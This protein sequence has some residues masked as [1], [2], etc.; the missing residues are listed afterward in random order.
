MKKSIFHPLSLITLF[1][2]AALAGNEASSQNPSAPQTAC[3]NLQK[4][5]FSSI[6]D[7]PT[8][9]T[10]TH[11]IEADGDAPAYCQVRG[12]V[13]PSIG[14]ELQLPAFDWNQKFLAV[15]CGGFCG[16][17]D[18][19]SC[20]NGLRRGYAC[21]ASD[22]GHKSHPG[23]ALWAY[24][25]LQAKIDHAYRATHVSA[26]A[27]KAIT[28]NYY[29]TPPRH[30]Y[31][32]GCSTGG[33][34]AMV[35]AQRFPWDF[36]GIIAGAP[37]LSVTGVH[38]AMLWTIRA[39]TD[40]RGKPLFSREDL[41]RAHAAVLQKCDLD[42]GVKDGIVSDPM[43]CAFDP[44]QLEC[45]RAGD[46]HCLSKVQVD[47]LKKVYRGPTTSKGEKI[48]PGALPGSELGLINSS[49]P[50]Q[51]ISGMNN[52]VANEF[53]YAAFPTDPGPD[54]NPA[55]FNFDRDP[56]RLGVMETLSSGTNPNLEKFKASGGKL[57][58]Y[59]GLNDH[60]QAKSTIEY[61]ETVIKT[62]G[63]L[64]AT[65][66]FFRLFTVPA[67]DHCTGGNGAFAVDYLEYLEAWV[68]RGEAPA[69]MIGSHVAGLDLGEAF[70]LKFP[71]E[72]SSQIDFTRP[73]YP[74]PATAKYNGRGNP[75]D[76]GNFHPRVDTRA[77]EKLTEET[78]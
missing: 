27:G 20:A 51:V 49:L 45:G 46:R 68:E 42:D 56:K 18:P 59:V 67:M 8:Q 44:A 64:S 41:Q 48:Y 3:Q 34:Q 4:N 23:D 71:L 5:S 6:P 38:M 7:A 11:F 61:Y 47:A 60:Y 21:L 30:A 1:F 40:S 33:R 53:R 13:Y 43:H 19:K 25:N 63:G 9:I 72:K 35:E 17:I 69:L 28:E 77:P 50:P 31:F 58:A 76:A 29:Q 2:I 36:D 73:L 10:E 70:Y 65:Q 16:A 78:R 24:N 32:M 39:L 62:M 75:D 57:I 74:Y 54:W 26:L 66:D 37:S 52:F 14:I 12:Y 22:M 15:G 55:D